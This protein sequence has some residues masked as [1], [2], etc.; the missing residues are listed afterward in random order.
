MQDK[1]IINEVGLRECF[2]KQKS[3]Y[4]IENKLELLDGLIL[5]G[6]KHI[7]LCSFVSQK[8]LPQMADA[9][10]LYYSAPKEENISYSA[11]ILN[12]KGLNRAVNCGFNK[13]ETSI[14][15]DDEYGL[16][17]TGMDGKRSLNELSNIADLAH[18]YDIKLRIG[19]Q[20]A[21]GKN[22]NKINFQI[23]SDKIHKIVA[24]DPNKICLAD[25]AG[26][27]TSDT[28]KEC[29]GIVI[30]IIEDIPLVMH[31]H[32]TQKGWKEN[33][34]S[35]IEMG[36]RE[37]DSSLGGMG[38]SPFLHKSMGNIPTE[39]LANLI[40]EKGFYSG[41]DQSVIQ[42]TVLKLNRIVNKMPDSKIV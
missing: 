30:P 4:S 5:S 15:L 16:T 33:V 20:C 23:L 18:K 3:L 22:N 12:V 42:K 14:S 2:Q 8:I 10:K 28:I 32:Q 27:A 39:E 26:V 31:F 21:W 24:M 29:L 19:L 40:D 13:L 38:G 41:V 7:Q 34:H 35:A 11:F 25:T 37:F 9:E 1:I 6:L 17:N 36:I